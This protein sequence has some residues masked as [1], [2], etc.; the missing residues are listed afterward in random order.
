MISPSTSDSSTPPKR[1]RFGTPRR[2]RVGVDIDG[3]LTDSY[4]KWLE[5]FRAN[6]LAHGHPPMPDSGIQSWD[7]LKDH[8]RVCY[9][10]CLFA[11]PV[12]LSHEFKIG[13]LDSLRALARLCELYC[14][15]SRCGAEE[16]TLEWLEYKGQ[17]KHAFNDVIFTHDKAQVCTDL[18]LDYHI[19]DSVAHLA[20]IEAGCPHTQTIIFDAPYN[21]DYL[22]HGVRVTDWQQIVRYLTTEIFQIV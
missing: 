14:V 21:R 6:D 4:L 13:A 5:H 8:C 11:K 19:D 7:W 15:T 9:D 1:K 22:L 16:G 3:V 17:I 20:A 12:L 18:L 10:E 2:P